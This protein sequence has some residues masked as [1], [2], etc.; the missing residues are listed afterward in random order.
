MNRIRGR[1]AG[2]LD[3]LLTRFAL[4]ICEQADRRAATFLRVLT[5]H[6]VD[7]AENRPALEPALAVRP[8][9][10]KRQLLFFSRHYRVVSMDRIVE[11]F[12]G[13]QPLP[14][15]ALAITFDDGYLDFSEHAWPI[16][17]QF[18]LPVTLFIPTAFPG[19]PGRY[20]WWDRLYHACKP[21]NGLNQIDTPASQLD[22][23]SA[24]RRARDLVKTLPHGK[25]MRW[26]EET[27]GRG[28]L[29]MAGNPV[30]DWDTLRQLAA[31]GVTLAPHTQT[32]PL[33]NRVS[34]DQAATEIL[35]SRED[36]E[37]EIGDVLPDISHISP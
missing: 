28:P 6:R 3:N 16:L 14:A 31:E 27:C 4:S 33:L 25:A 18:Q 7:E 8:R 12:S 37:R 13:G 24:H 35:G 34:P 1:V 22:W 23:E 19:N 17:K 11:A 15:R 5:Y 26:I 20:F 10:F 29:E 2:L 32:H 30:L 21:G 36:L 9:E